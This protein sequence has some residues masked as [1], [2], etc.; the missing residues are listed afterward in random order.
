MMAG[1]KSGSL[2]DITI[3]VK[4]TDGR[5]YTVVKTGFSSVSAGS[6]RRI[7]LDFSNQ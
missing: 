1:P 3:T 7:L 5:E 2:G 4:M 6:A